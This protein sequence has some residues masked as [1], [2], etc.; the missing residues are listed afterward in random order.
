MLLKRLDAALVAKPLCLS[1][2]A[3]RDL[4]I[5]N[6]VFEALSVIR[7]ERI[8]ISSSHPG[9]QS[10]SC[11]LYIASQFSSG[12]ENAVTTGLLATGAPASSRP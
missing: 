9:L 1:D 8:D 6:M 11:Q 2:R 10:K 7:L 3:Y 5:V 4:A 12:S